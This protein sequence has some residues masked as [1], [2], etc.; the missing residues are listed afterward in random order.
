MKALILA[1]G[2]GTRLRSVL[3]DIPKPLAPVKDIPYLSYVLNALYSQGLREVILS[4]GYKAEQFLEFVA[5]QEKNL[6]DLSI[7][8]V[9]ESQPLGTGGAIKHCYDQYPDDS[10]LVFNGDSYCDFC[11]ETMLANNPTDIATMVVANVPDISRY[12]EVSLFENGKVKAFHEKKGLAQEGWINAGIYYFSTDVFKNIPVGESFSF[13]HKIIPQ[14]LNAGL[15]TLKARGNFID[16]GIPDD[17]QAMC[18]KPDKYF[19]LTP[20]WEQ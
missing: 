13:E 11:L 17:Y 19:A 5:I 20:A 7:V 2:L 1:G 4:V 3:N 16:I 6:P 14:L 18:D 9:T 10:Y 12:G 15:H 8:L